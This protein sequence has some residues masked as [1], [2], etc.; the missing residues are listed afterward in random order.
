MAKALEKEIQLAICDYL[1]L[2]RYFFWRQN[3]TAVFDPSQKVFRAM[4]KYSLNG[5]P[6]IILIHKGQF[7][8]IEV[9]QPKG[10]QSDNQRIFEN[11]CKKAGG[12][13]HI[14]TSLDDIIALGL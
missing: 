12:Q 7:V 2:K 10:K 5:V 9:K 8:G 3:T 6:D 13:Y 14:V 11:N 4:P 1:S